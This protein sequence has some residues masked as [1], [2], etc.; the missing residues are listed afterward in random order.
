MLLLSFRF[1]VLAI[2]LSAA[3][4]SSAAQSQMPLPMGHVEQDTKAEEIRELVSKYCRLD[5]AGARLDPQGWTKLESLVWW[6]TNPAYTQMDVISRYTV[7]TQPVSTHGKF[8]VTVHYRVLGRF[9][10]AIGYTPEAANSTEDVEYTV[11][12]VNDEW[13]I[14]DAEPNFPHPSRDAMLKWLNEKISTT[15]DASTR[16]VYEEALRRLQA[17]TGSPLAK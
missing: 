11:T 8:T 3:A 4:A 13:R 7:E 10:P 16:T 1:F 12:A 6:K 14:D 17:P 15:Q 5:Y 9:E 2:V